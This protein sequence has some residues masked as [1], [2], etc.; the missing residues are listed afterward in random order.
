M[1]T[2]A[3]SAAPS[4][5][6]SENTKFSQASAT[7]NISPGDWLVYS[8]Q[9]VFA[10]N[11]GH[12]AYWKTSGAGIATDANPT[13]DQAGRSVVNSALLYASDI[14]FWASAAFSG[15]PTLGI[16]AYPVSTGSAVGAVTGLTGVASTWQTAQVRF[17]SALSGTANGQQAPVA[18]V[19]G[20]RN[21][22]NAGTGELLLRVTHPAPDVRG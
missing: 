3:L 10:S 14:T 12:T 6:N 11:S 2:T 8:G 21:F 4:I 9:H 7:G 16:G 1:S 20:S 5:P 18:T 17:G 13:Y 15:Q 22:S 19:I